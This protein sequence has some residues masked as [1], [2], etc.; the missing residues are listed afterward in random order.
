MILPACVLMAPDDIIGLKQA[1]HLAGKDPKTIRDWCRK[2]GIGSRPGG[3]G[4]YR[5]SLPGLQMVIAEDWRALELLR[6]GRRSAPEV[7]RHLHF[8]GLAA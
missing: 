3:G 7:M 1:A 2:H 5:V 4:P 8:L 6:E